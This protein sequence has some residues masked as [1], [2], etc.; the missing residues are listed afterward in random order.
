MPKTRARI[1]MVLFFHCS[2][3]ARGEELV[4]WDSDRESEEVVGGGEQE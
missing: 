2:G 1:L 4:N 3:W